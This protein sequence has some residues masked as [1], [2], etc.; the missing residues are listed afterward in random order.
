MRTLLE[1]I[2]VLAALSV[3]L[4]ACAP[5][6]APSGAAR[7]SLNR[8]QDPA[9]PQDDVSTLV[10]GNNAFALDLYQSLRSQDGNLAFSPYSISL[11]LGMTYAGAR[12]TTEQQ[13]AQVLHYTLPQDRL[14]P[15][16]NRLD[17]D[18]EKEGKPASD[19]EQPLQL[20][21]ANAV[22]AEQT[23]SF[24]Q[25]YLDLIAT[26]YGAGVQ[27]ADFVSNYEAVRQEINS[28]VSKQTNDRI[29]DLIPQGAL[30][31]MT[32]MVLVNAIYFKADWLNQFDPND[33]ND[34][35]FHL[36]D[37]SQVTS[38]MMSNTLALSYMSGDGYQA[39]ELPY[40]GETA[41]MDIIVPDEGHF[42]DIEAK[43]DAQEFEKVVNG[44]Q[45]TMLQLGLPKF[46]YR[47]SFGLSNTLSSMGMPEAF[48]G[49]RADF[50]GMTGNHDLY[51][52]EVLHQAF[53]AVD[54]KGTEAAAAT[55]VVMRATAAMD[56]PKRLTIDRP[57]LYVIRDLQGG[58]ILFVGRVMDPTK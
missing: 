18:L 2:S 51:I 29:K 54:E 15:A 24:V 38:K 13:M 46:S 56:A 10:Q 26:N 52:S 16:F 20:K 1:I 48:N 3:L 6:P 32:R 23:Y 44:L 40:V 30:D 34:Q 12:G 55:A 11:A 28:W 39:V 25:A 5:S 35:P 21:I 33:T 42:K 41:A 37:G 49:S 14:H 17:Q 50:S 57:F 58:Q 45:P 53:V 43:L 19:E 4:T 22:W 31:S 47:S 8:V 27:L 9:V 36:M 7:S